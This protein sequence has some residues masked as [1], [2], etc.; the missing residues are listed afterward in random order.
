M[1]GGQR[2]KINL[3]T[4]SV[5]Y[6]LKLAFDLIFFKT[7]TLSVIIFWRPAIVL[8]LS[9]YDCG[10]RFVENASLWKVLLLFKQINEDPS[11]SRKYSM[12][13][14]YQS[15]NMSWIKD[16]IFENKNHILLK[17]IL[18]WKKSRLGWKESGVPN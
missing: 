8:L 3:G 13:I 5:W 9:N 17:K 12:D 18:N 6:F 7:K 11:V 2:Q 1:G 4:W 15:N 14:S 10:L 16:H